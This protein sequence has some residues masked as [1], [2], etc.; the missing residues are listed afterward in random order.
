MSRTTNRLRAAGLVAGALL[1]TACSSGS[2]EDTTTET[3]MAPSSAGHGDDGHDHDHGAAG[4]GLS[5]MAEGFTLNLERLEFPTADETVEFAF[6]I[7]GEDGAPVTSFEEHHEKLLHLVLVSHD[8]EQYQHL[9]PELDASGRWSVETS[10]PQEGF[11]HLVAD[12]VSDGKAAVLGTDFRVGTGAMRMAEFTEDVRT[13]VN[14][15]YT[16]TLIGDTAHEASRPLKVEFTRDGEPVT[17]V[18][19]YLGANA[20]MVAFAQSDLGY[21]HM[22]PNDGFVDGVMTFTAPPMGHDFY[23]VFVEADFD[24]ELRLFEFVYYGE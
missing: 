16:A 11:W 13:S 3:T 10:F 1:I 7:V 2:S 19:P 9:H 17:S 4:A 22:H 15:P 23:K 20:H 14:G 24:G 18:N 12:F 6:S 5:P 21:T 8:L